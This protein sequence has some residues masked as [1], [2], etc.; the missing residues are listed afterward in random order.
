MDFYF[1]KQL[2]SFRQTL[3]ELF[4]F[5]PCNREFVINDLKLFISENGLRHQKKGWS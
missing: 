4:T 3:R 2:T 5:S 1:H